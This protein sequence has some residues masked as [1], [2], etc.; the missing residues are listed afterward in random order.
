MKL[1]IIDML[2]KG[3]DLKKEIRHQKISEGC[4]SKSISIQK[5]MMQNLVSN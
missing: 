3:L 2:A 1:Q 4:L 5:I